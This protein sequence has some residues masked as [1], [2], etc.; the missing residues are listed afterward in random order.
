MLLKSFNNWVLK[1]M[2]CKI[3]SEHI[4]NLILEIADALRVLMDILYLKKL[5]SFKTD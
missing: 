3:F 5:T 2:S 4:Q 1:I